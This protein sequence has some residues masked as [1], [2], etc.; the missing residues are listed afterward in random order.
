[1]HFGGQL[2]KRSAFVASHKTV[3]QPHVVRIDHT[4]GTVSR[5]TSE[6]LVLASEQAKMFT[7]NQRLNEQ[8]IACAFC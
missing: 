1:M 3:K 4:S 6:N 7:K 2:L 8:P 5:Y